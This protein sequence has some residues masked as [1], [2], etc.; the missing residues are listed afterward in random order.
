MREDSAR[1]VFE[2]SGFDDLYA[3]EHHW[4]RPITGWHSAKTFNLPVFSF[5]NTEA[6]ASIV[7]KQNERGQSI[8][9][10]MS[11]ERC[12]QIDVS[13]DLSVDDHKSFAFEKLAR[14]IQRSAGPENY[15]FFNVMKFDAE[16]TAVAKC[17]TNRLRPVMQV[18]NYLVDAV[19]SEIFGDITN[20]WFSE[21]WYCG[22]GA[23]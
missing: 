1:N 10:S 15:G 2:D 7:G 12:A 9:V 17:S 20:E 22:L 11:L 8:C 16:P 14:V 19:R 4:R 13:N 23:I 5:D 3:R 21:N 6:L 18:Y